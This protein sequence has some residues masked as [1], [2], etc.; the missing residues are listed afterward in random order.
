LI[1]IKFVANATLSAGMSEG[2]HGLNS[3]LRAARGLGMSDEKPRDP[4]EDP[5][6]LRDESH[7]LN[8]IV[9]VLSDPE[10]KKE[11]ASHS[12]YLAQ[13]AEALSRIAEDPAIIRMNIERY[14]SIL[15]SGADHGEEHTIQVLLNQAEQSLEAHGSLRELAAW[16]RSFAE[17]AGNPTIW[18]A[19][20][21]MAEDLEAEADRIQRRNA[22]D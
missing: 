20:L 22:A 4:L 1:L 2:Y 3:N 11:L 10:V 19:R 14:R 21:L 8:K 6:Y 9:R 15:E 12:L 7:R 17:R 13:R 18:E 16:Y 5:E